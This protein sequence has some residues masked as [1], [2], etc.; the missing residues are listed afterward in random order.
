MAYSVRCGVWPPKQC[1]A[2]LSTNIYYKLDESHEGESEW[3][4]CK[5]C[6]ANQIYWFE[7]VEEGISVYD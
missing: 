7:N 4:W 3:C 6:K 5:D 2:C 1:Q